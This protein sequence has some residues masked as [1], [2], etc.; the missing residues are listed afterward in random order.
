[1]ADRLRRRRARRRERDELTSEQL[2]ARARWQRRWNLPILLA[3][4][5]PLFVTSPQSRITQIV[6]G[7]GSWL[8]FLIDLVVQRRIAPSYLRT[9]RGHVDLVI[10]IFT[11]PFYLL[12]G[13]GG[14]T[15]ILLL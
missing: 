6:V 8:V 11:F 9:R 2:A 15:A 1:M 13:A 4:L 5:V 7:V 3:A 14:Y 12:P 10:V